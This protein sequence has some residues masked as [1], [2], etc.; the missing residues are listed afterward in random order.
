MTRS[1]VLPVQESVGLAFDDPV[2]SDPCLFLDTAT[3]SDT[4]PAGNLHAIERRVMKF[5]LAQPELRF[6]SLTV[7]RTKEGV[8]LDGVLESTLGVDVAEMVRQIDG[9]GQVYNHL[10]TRP[11]ATAHAPRLP[12]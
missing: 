11:R 6:S 10:V 1:K 8:C 12:R 3:C 7:R 2:P 9:V 5:L 4:Q